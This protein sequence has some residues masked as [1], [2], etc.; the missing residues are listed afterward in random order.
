MT[1]AEFHAIATADAS[2]D[3][4]TAAVRAALREAL[5][6]WKDAVIVLDLQVDRALA[7][8]KERDG[9]RAE[10]PRHLLLALANATD[11]FKRGDLAA[12]ATIN[13]NVQPLVD[14][15]IAWARREQ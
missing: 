7:A 11:A 15:A 4:K 6:A 2:D 9:A 8:E 10:V 3:P 1:Q 12:L 5:R 14:A 13:M